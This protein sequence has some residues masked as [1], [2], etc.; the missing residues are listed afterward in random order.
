[1]VLRMGGPSAPFGRRPDVD[2]RS[3]HAAGARLSVLIVEGDPVL[4]AEMSTWLEAEHMKVDSCPGPHL[5]RPSCPFDASG[6]CEL[7]RS[8]DVVV[9]DEWL[10]SDTFLEGAPGWELAVAYHALGTPLV[11]LASRVDAVSFEGEASVIRLERPPRRGTLIR[12][13]RS[14]A[15]RRAAAPILG[16]EPWVIDAVPSASRG[17][18]DS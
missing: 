6:P 17:R 3:V 16:D 12:A 15:G 7:V 13:V 14:A 2:D 5:V 1:M 18:D 10:E 8:A 9:L 11:L 4:R